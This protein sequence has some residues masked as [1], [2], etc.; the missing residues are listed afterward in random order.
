MLYIIANEKSGNGAAK[1]ALFEITTYLTENHIPYAF[2]VSDY[3]GHSKELA[4]RAIKDGRKDIVVIGGDGTISEVIN[5][6]AGR[7][8]TVIFISCGTG[9]DF[10]RMLD[11]PEGPLEAFRAQL[12]GESRKIDVGR[13]NDDYFLNISGAGFD[14]EVLIQYEKF[15]HISN[16]ILPYMLGIFAALKNFRPL[17]IELEHDGIKTVRDVT[18]ISVGNGRFIGGG[19]M[20]VPTA[21]ID[22]GLF[23]VVIADKLNRLQIMQFLSKFIKGKHMDLPQIESFRCEKLTIA[24]PHMTVESDGEL[25]IMNS[26]KYEIL[27]KALTIR[28]PKNPEPK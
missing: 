25:K 7:P 6:I 16:G 26:A 1:R 10:V 20:A 18:I 14:T 22:D 28:C 11:I 21:E 24:C 23:D 4:D 9:N 15:K 19:M 5:G 2:D 3:A 17:H 27:P 13:I 8:A 12:F